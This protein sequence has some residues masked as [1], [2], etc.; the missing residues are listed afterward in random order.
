MA[1]R[2]YIVSGGQPNLKGGVGGDKDAVTTL[3]SSDAR[4]DP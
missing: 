1:Y 2:E 3:G 4:V